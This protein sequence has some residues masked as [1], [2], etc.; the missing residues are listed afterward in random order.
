MFGL[1]VS[2]GSKFQGDRAVTDIVAQPLS[3]KSVP[4]PVDKRLNKSANP[5]QPWLGSVCSNFG[6]SG[7]LGLVGTTVGGLYW[8]DDQ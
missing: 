1:H 6:H 4:K 7:L 5:V 2:M 8:M 3:P